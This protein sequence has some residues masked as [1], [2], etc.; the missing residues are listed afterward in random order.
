[1]A[2]L[3]DAELDKLGE[4]PERVV[5][6]GLR[7]AQVY[8]VQLES[9]DNAVA[10][11]RRVLDADV[12]NQSAVR[13]LDRLFSQSERWAE[14]T[15]VLKREA[16]IGQ[17]PD[18]ILEFKFRLGQV[19]QLRLGDVDRAIDAYREVINAAPEHAD[20]LA[21][22]E[23]LFESGVKQLEIAEI[24]EPL[25][26]QAGEWEKLIRVREAELIHITDADQRIAMYHRIAED[27]EERL[28]D[29]VRAFEVHVRAIR[30]RPLEERTGEESRAPRG[31]DRRRLGTARERLR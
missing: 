26:Q 13:A 21:A 29:P 25:Y 27:A 5:E 11:Y 20:T 28:M 14:L 23:G 15:E 9:L 10:R 31:H 12:E 17:S 18:E 2:E 22:L 1:M 3:Y 4:E 24:L 19:Y 7:V 30:E 16:D 6:L 8:E